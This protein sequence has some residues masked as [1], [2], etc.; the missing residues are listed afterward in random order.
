MITASHNPPQYNGIKIFNGEGV[1]YGEKSQNKIGEIMRHERFKLVEWRNIGHAERTE[2]NQAYAK[3][4]EEGVQLRRKRYV[5]VDPGCGATY[6]LAPTILRKV[7]CNV[8]AL[9]AQPDGW[10]PARSPEPTAQSV[11]SLAHVVKIAKSDAGLG[12]DGDGDRAVFVDEKGAFADLDRTLAA[13]AAHVTKKCGGGT[14]VT[15]VEASMCVEKM[16]EAQGGKVVRT[17]VGDIHVSEEMKRQKAVFGGEPCGAWIHP[18]FHCCPDGILSSVLLLQALEDEKKSL[19]ELVAQTPRYSILRENFTCP[20]DQKNRILT[21]VEE[22]L[23]S[24]FPTYKE[25]STVDGFR[26]T[27]ENGWILVRASGTE[28][29]VRLTVEGESLRAAKQIIEKGSIVIKK[30]GGRCSR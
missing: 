6:E 7:G 30:S 24:A 21:E 20:N 8:T 15:T 26:L 11:T 23:K 28:P 13:Y 12:Y 22:K 17:K 2:Q 5:V 18:Q 3:M 4:I 25:A 14:V 10:F 1:A 16:V 9:N 29:T 19:A 27:L